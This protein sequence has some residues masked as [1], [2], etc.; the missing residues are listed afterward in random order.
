[1]VVVTMVKNKNFIK[2]GKRFSGHPF[3]DD[4]GKCVVVDIDTKE[5]Y[6]YDSVRAYEKEY[7]QR[8]EFDA[9]TFKITNLRAYKTFTVTE[10]K[11][12]LAFTSDYTGKPTE[13]ASELLVDNEGEMYFMYWGLKIYTKELKRIK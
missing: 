9:Y 5:V 7:A 12:M 1:M 11:T 2:D 10:S 4:K 6:S 13:T 8:Y 3:V